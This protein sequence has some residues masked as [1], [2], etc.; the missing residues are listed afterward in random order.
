MSKIQNDQ[1]ARVL[2]DELRDDELALV[3]GGAYEGYIPYD[4]AQSAEKNPARRVMT[5]PGDR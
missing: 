2:R 3:H 5:G 4:S 1:A